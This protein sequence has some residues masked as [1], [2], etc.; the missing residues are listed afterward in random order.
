MIRFL[1]DE[2]F[3]GKIVRGVL[4]ERPDADLVRVQDTV[5]YRSPDPKLLEWAA[6]EG[7]IVLSHDI[8]TMVGFAYERIRGGLPMPGLIVAHE[9]LPVGHVIEELLV[10]LGASEMSEWGNRIK[11]L[12]L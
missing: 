4:R 9:S 12:P 3:N 1:A 11:F 10:I 5:I 8:N 7:R 2:N 6:Q